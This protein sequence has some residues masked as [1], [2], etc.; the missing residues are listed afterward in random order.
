MLEIAATERLM[1]D[2]LHHEGAILS[3]DRRFRFALS[4]TLLGGTLPAFI[5][6]PRYCAF[7]LLNPSTAS[8]TEDDPTIRKCRGFAQRWGY[9]AFDVVNL[10]AWRATNPDELR[11]LP[12]SVITA[13]ETEND[14]WIRAVARHAEIVVVGWGNDGALLNRG[15]RVRA[16]LQAAGI[17]LHC[18]EITKAEQPKHPLYVPYAQPLRLLPVRGV[19]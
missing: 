9:S 4:R 16:M 19:A 1:I 17:P 6:P 18:W 7:V 3:P 5:E 12:A 8:E 15:Q 2:R 13:D 11:K 14:R 10:F